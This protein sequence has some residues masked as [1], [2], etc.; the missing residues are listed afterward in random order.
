[1]EQKLNK[2]KTVTDE[3]TTTQKTQLMYKISL[4]KFLNPRTYGQTSF[5]LPN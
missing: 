2:G 1:M 5:Y 3:K 4:T